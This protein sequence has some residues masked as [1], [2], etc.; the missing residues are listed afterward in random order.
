MTAGRS[1]V[2][3]TDFDITRIAV[4]NPAIADAVVV[5]PRE[6][7]V[8]GKGAGHRQPDHLGRRYPQAVRRG[9][10]C[11]RQP[12]AAEFPGSVSRRRHQRF[13]HRK[14]G[15]PLGVGLEQRGDASRR[16]DCAR[17]VSEELDRQH[18]A[19]AGGSPSNQVM[20][21]VRFAEVNRNAFLQ[22]GLNLFAAHESFAARSTTQQFAGAGFRQRKP[23][24]LRVHG[25]PQPV[26]LSSRH[27]NRRRPE[28]V[29]GT[30]PAAEPGGTEPDRLQRPGGEL[31]GRRRGSDS[32]RP[33]PHR[34]HQR[35]LQGIR[36][37]AEFHADHC[38]RC[39]SS[40][41]ASRSQ[42]A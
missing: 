19:I 42:H 22:A 8:D 40:Q 31:P 5:K 35:R 34:Q 10:R 2:V 41:A 14:L 39:D 24:L 33:G 7:L 20:L 21:Q 9:R 15:H 26:L 32:G 17:G 28:G 6:V 29:A 1:T 3:T 4:T 37:A 30:R 18:A 23:D 27:R 36:R 25:L 13:G 12:A 38:R 16:G 11:R